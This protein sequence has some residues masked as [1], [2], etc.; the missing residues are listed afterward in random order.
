MK[1]YYDKDADLG[2]IKGKKVTIVGYGSQGHAHA[3]NLK[4]SGATV[5]IGLRK[6]GSSW[7]K[8]VAAGH[9]TLE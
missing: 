8:A 7:A 1:V 9:N 3:A 5:T 2:L 6:G 4:D